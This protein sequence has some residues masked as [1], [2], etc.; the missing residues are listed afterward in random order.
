MTIEE[1]LTT[2]LHPTCPR[3]K[4]TGSRMEGSFSGN[5]DIN[6]WCFTCRGTGRVLLPADEL[7]LMVELLRR[8][9]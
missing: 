6:R 7:T 1:L 4:G 3:C 9:L 8:K 2:E 5:E